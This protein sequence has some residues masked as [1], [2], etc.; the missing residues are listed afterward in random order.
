M[1]RRP[2]SSLTALFIALI[3][4]GALNPPACGQTETGTIYGSV[5]DPTGAVVS[6]AIV[7]LID[8]DRGA[9]TEVATGTSGF[10][11][12]T[13]VGPGHYQM[14]VEKSGFKLI[15]LSG[16]TV[17]VQDNLEQN[18]KLGLGSA[19]ETIT[20]TADAAKVNTTDGTVSTVVDRTFAE[21]LPLNGRSFQ[22]LIMLTPG[23]VVTQTAFD[24]QGQFSVN[25]QRADAN[26]FTVDGVSANFGVTGYQPLV[27][28]ASGALPALSAQGGTNSLVSVDAM[29]EFRVQSSSFAPEFGRTPGGQISIATRSGTN[30]FHGTLF[31][32]FRNDKLDANNWFVGYNHLS[33]PAERQNDFGGVFSGPILKNKIFFFF[34]YEGLRLRQPTTQETVVPDTPSRQQAAANVQPY[35]GA[36]PIA[37]GSELGQG[38]AQFNGSYSNPSSV[39]AYSIRLD[40]VVNSKITLFGRYNYSPNNFDLRGPLAVPDPILSQTEPVSS[41]IHTLTIGLTELIRSNIS[42]EIRA[43]YSNAR[44]SKKLLLDTFGGAVPPSESLLFPP[45]HSPAGSAFYLFVPQIG[46]YGEG[47]EATDEQRQV[48][49]I[50]NLSLITGT[51]QLKFGVDYRWL[52]PFESRAQYEQFAQFS[53]IPCPAPPTPCSGYAV[54]GTTSFASVQA[55]QGDALL[56]RNFSIY[57]QDTWKVTPRLTLTYGLRWELNPPL[58]GKNLANQPFTVTGLSAPSTIALAPRGT[59]LYDTT[60]GNF[61]PRVGVALQLGDRPNWGSVLRGGFGMFYDLGSGPLGG[62]SNYFP[63]TASKPLGSVT[64]PIS[65]NDAAPPVIT[66]NP[67]VQNILVAD[68]HLDLP[69]TYEWNVAWEQSLGSSQTVSASYVGAAGR[70]LLR[71]TDLISPNSNFFLI[72]VT[73]NSATSNYNAMQLKFERRLSRGLQALASYTWSHSIDIASTDAFANYLNTPSSVADPNVDRGSSDFDI[74]HAV[75]AGVTY[76]VPTPEWNSVA[77]TVLGGWSVDSFIFARSAPPVNVLSGIYFADGVALDPRPNLVPGIPLVLYGSQYPGGKAINNT[78]SPA[79]PACP[80]PFKGPFCP[81]PKGTQGDFP[82]NYLRAFGGSQVDLAFQRQFPLTEKLRL[83][84]RGEFFNIFNH[85]NF[86]PQNNTITDALF[87]YSTAPLNNSLGSGGA[88]G[89]LNPLYQIGGPRSIQLALKLQF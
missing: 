33:K 50:D 28:A 18:F 73:S 26:Y 76:N 87:G 58:K 29:Q 22:T 24:D 54:S 12:L 4:I 67:P 62:V 55:F 32:Y 9:K 56:S 60:Y 69:R 39:N 84:F 51:H 61:A 64:L 72:G 68:P 77:R 57:G 11:S 38:I 89:G 85:P 14:E 48:N 75:T 65:P 15:R 23:V 79:G 2:S 80:V 78:P 8:V 59:P 66:T 6:N 45:G 21:G 44:V 10:Y 13:D 36:Y 53:G 40:H 17:N 47:K 35:L 83:R 34:S 63:Y 5:T 46:E 27:Q 16:I 20:V 37:N 71:N 86:G 43:N 19:S 41:S 81:A 52:S 42:N 1:T 30:A 31:E 74:R 3:F 70:D 49:L 88:N 82:R 7:R 25:G